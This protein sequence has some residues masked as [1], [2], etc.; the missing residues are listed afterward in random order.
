MLPKIN[1]T[2]MKNY[3]LLLSVIFAI[4]SCVRMQH[5]EREVMVIEYQSR[6]VVIDDNS[7]AV[8]HLD[9]DNP[10]ATL[11][12]LH[13]CKDGFTLT[14]SIE[15]ESIGAENTILE[16]P[17]ML[18]VC[19]RLHEREKRSA[20]N[21]SAYPMPDGSI[22]VLEALLWLEDETG[23]N[24]P[25]TVGLPLSMLDEPFGMH[26]VCLQFTGVKWSIYVDNCLYDNDFAVG[27]P[28]VSGKESWKI[29][30]EKVE[31]AD[32][33]VP[34]L[35]L[36][37][38][39]AHNI[40]DTFN[41]HFWTP[42]F[43]NA[44]VGD[45]ATIYH[46]GRYHLFYLFDRR[47]HAGKFGRGGHYFEHLSTTDFKHWTEHR[48]ATPVEHQW[49][50]I[51]TGT[52]FVYNGQLCLSYGLHTTRMYP[53]ERTT[54]P[55][56]WK[57]LEDNG[58]T[59]SFN[60]DTI[61]GVMPAGST[62]SISEDGISNFKKTHILIHPCENPSIYTTKDGELQMLA[63][64]GARGTWSSDSVAGGWKCINE[65]FPLGGDC[66]FPFHWNGYDYI[67]GGFNGLWYKDSDVAD[68]EYIDMVKQ[69]IDF[70][71]GMSVPSITEITDN[72]FLMAAWVKTEGWGGPLVIHELIQ[73][74][75][76]RIGSKWM[77]EIIPA[78]EAPI[79][80]SSS[81]EDGQMIDIPE[82]PLILTFEVCPLN[83]GKGRMAVTFQNRE[84]AENA[85]EWQLQIDKERAQFA[86]AVTSGFAPEEKTLREGGDVSTAQNYA[87][88]DGMTFERPFT[89]RMLIQP[90]AKVRGTLMD[91]EIGAQRTML[92]Y[93]PSLFVNQLKFH[94]DNVEIKGLDYAILK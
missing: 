82:S 13:S 36:K 57:F 33:Y 14:F 70:Y 26:N 59:G 65:H 2:L 34:A 79:A 17:E 44:W 15:L 6:Y 4:S 52:P 45:V 47:G 16:I 76:G 80:M 55:M 7:P 19:T 5:K 68:N 58:Y 64:Y 9:K 29:D 84:S 37:E 72:R 60:Y 39:P 69:G 73:H 61:A 3:F 46:R 92:S 74:S 32:L 77:E 24:R 27:Y 30:A 56:Q 54:L 10:I 67:I 8:S 20:Q 85:C 31:K 89:V 81:I 1:H 38:A 87:I 51:G 83:N 62:Y 94:L 25:L 12:E 21:Y 35:S 71:N 11:P 50:C 18:K 75:D 66:T 43:H 41:I 48:A 88:E 90:S 86:P 91:V 78:T 63:N 22:P 42:P 40:T 23:H 53:R 28:R 93:R 49:E